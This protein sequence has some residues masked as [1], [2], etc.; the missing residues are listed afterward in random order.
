MEIL[1]L[2][3]EAPLMS[4]GGPMVDNHG[5]IQPFPAQSMLTGLL[6]NALGWDHADADALDR[7]QARIH[8]AARL[9][10]PGKTISDYQTADLGQPFMKQTGWTTRGAPEWRAGAQSSATGTQI[11]YRTYVADAL[12]TVFLTLAGE[13]KTPNLEQLADALSH[14]A[15]PLFIGRKSCLPASPILAGRLSA[16][17]LYDALRHFGQHSVTGEGEITPQ[18]AMSACWP[19]GQGPDHPDQT[20]LEPVTDHRDWLNQIHGG[21]RLQRV[22]QII[23]AVQG[24]SHD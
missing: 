11:R 1:V 7:L 24:N 9:D 6:A 10:R 12:C 23:P 21:Q 15:R 13:E 22:G 17:N 19:P 20:V 4:F 18:N 8:F 16:D 3:L 5:V 14:P 2:R